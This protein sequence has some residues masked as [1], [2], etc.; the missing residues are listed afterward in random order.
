MEDLRR[1][2]DAVVAL[3]R[4]GGELRDEGAPAIASRVD[5]LISSLEA[6]TR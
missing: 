4:L 2:A 3:S 1:I 6:S 5:H